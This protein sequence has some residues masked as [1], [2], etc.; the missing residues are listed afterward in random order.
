[1]FIRYILVLFLLF[2]ANKCFAVDVNIAQS[3]SF[4]DVIFASGANIVMDPY[5]NI[6]SNG[7]AT[8]FGN[9][10]PTILNL[11]NIDTR[12]RFV[13]PRDPLSN[14]G[15]TNADVDNLTCI[16]PGYIDTAV[17]CDDISNEVVPSSVDIYMGGEVKIESQSR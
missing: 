3:M 2:S 17:N 12:L 1:M 15:S 7:G 13:R 16:I 9:T 11:T 5:G 14:I 6:T 4:G 8:I 10:K